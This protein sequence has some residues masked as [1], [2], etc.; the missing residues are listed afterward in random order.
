MIM[1]IPFAFSGLQLR[2]R[3]VRSWAGDV[4]DGNRCALVIGA[5]LKLR[6]G[7]GEETFRG[8]PSANPSL[9]DQP[10]LEKMFLKAADLAF[11]ITKTYGPP[12][13]ATPGSAAIPLLKGRKGVVY[14][15]HCWQTRTE[16]VTFSQSR[17]GDHIDLWDGS[18]I[19]IYR[20]HPFGN[21]LVAHA[22]NVLFWE[23]QD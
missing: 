6:P 7:P 22:E 4:T 2:L 18:V 11:Q 9:R 8:Q 5:T 20:T 3:S 23:C 17:S 14:L 13:L 15:K 21:E 12:T 1:P 19:E 16:K 10:F